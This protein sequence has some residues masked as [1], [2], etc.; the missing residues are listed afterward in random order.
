MLY[1]SSNNN[2]SNKLNFN[3]PRPVISFTNYL[4]DGVISFVNY[5][6]DGVI[7]FTNYLVDGVIS[8]MNYSANHFLQVLIVI[9]PILLLVGY[10]IYHGI[11]PKIRTKIIFLE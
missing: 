9:I 10:I 8:F 1:I 3:L 5:L 7:S 4:V 6:V 11:N 2:E